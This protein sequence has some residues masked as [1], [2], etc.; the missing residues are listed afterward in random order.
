[1]KEIEVKALLQLID[2]FTAPAKEIAGSSHKLQKE[3]ADTQKELEQLSQGANQD[4]KHLNDLSKRFD[5]AKRKTLETKRAWN[6]AEQ[7]VKQLAQA[8]KQ[9]EKPTRAQIQIFENAKKKTT[10]LKREYQANKSTLNHLNNE[11]RE[12]SQRVDN[13]TR[14]MDKLDDSVKK[15]NDVLKHQKQTMKGLNDA[16]KHAGKAKGH[17][18]D[19]ASYGAKL[20]GI[21]A[22]VGY[23]F[24]RL[25]IDTA[26]QFESYLMVLENI[27]GSSEKAKSSFDWINSW[28]AKTPFEIDNATA[29]FVKLRS[30]GFDPMSGTLTTLGNAASGLDK[31]IMDGVEAIADAVMGE[32]ERLKE[33]FNIKASVKGDTITYRYTDLKDQ[34]EKTVTAIKDNKES[35]EKAILGIL[36]NNFAGMMEKQS[37][38]WRGMVSNLADTWTR[39]VNKIMSAGLFDWMK[40]K[41]AGILKYLDKL[42]A[43][44]KLNEW[45][46]NIGNNIKEIFQNICSFG[47]G[48]L[49]LFKSVGHWLNIG[50]E[51]LGGWNNL[52]L[53]LLTLPIVGTLIGLTSSIIGVVAALKTLGVSMA[54]LSGMSLPVVTVIAAIGVASYA[55]YKHWDK[56]SPYFSKLWSGIKAI[57]K[58]AWSVVKFLFN[59]SPLG[60]I[61]NNWS[62]I[63]NIFDGIWNKIKNIFSNGKNFILNTLKNNWLTGWLFNDKEINA[64][65]N[66]DIVNTHKITS[67][68]IPKEMYEFGK[69]EFPKN[70]AN[71]PVMLA[72]VINLSTVPDLQKAQAKNISQT[73]EIHNSFTINAVQG[74]DEEKI[75]KIVVQK[76]KEAQRNAERQARGRLHDGV[77]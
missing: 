9:S 47:A 13:Y 53:V 2:E 25:F 60:L 33:A 49:S 68:D 54:F 65:I 30:Y 1:M 8:I 16:Y 29:A 37:K 34:Q 73:N 39:G 55:L 75:A 72:P 67:Q 40:G 41:L 48:L 20:G 21:F 32:N 57:F 44:G 38:T 69:F 18:K 36:D 6:Q 50:A 11:M 43:E 59:W 74:M 70:S 28:A 23:G 22:L 71:D 46:I 24:K 15:V 64:N 52:A 61:T 5:A 26:S 62:P 17:L 77:A 45:A 51:A 12:A 4:A 14:K 19:M 63:I 76:Q 10:Q 27:E 66:K 3:L 7:E 42:E 58:G 35:I 56:I 31:D